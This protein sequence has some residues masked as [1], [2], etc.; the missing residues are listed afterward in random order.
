MPSASSAINAFGDKC[1]ALIQKK[2]RSYFKNPYFFK[3]PLVPMF[4][5]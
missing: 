1:C 5:V 2:I 4:A 3:D